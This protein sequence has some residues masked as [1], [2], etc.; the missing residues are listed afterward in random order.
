[1]AI[2]TPEIALSD[3]AELIE[4]TTIKIQMRGPLAFKNA[5]SL[6]GKIRGLWGRYLLAEAMRGSGEADRLLAAIYN[7]GG[8]RSAPF[9]LSIDDGREI[10]QVKVDLFGDVGRLRDVAASTLL[11]AISQGSPGPIRQS[12]L[13]ASDVLNCEWSRT[14]GCRDT[15]LGTDV[16]LKFLMPFKIGGRKTLSMNYANLWLAAAKRA[17]DLARAHGFNLKLS[18]ESVWQAASHLRHYDDAL[19]PLSWERWTSRNGGRSEAMMGFEGEL[20][21]GNW[22]SELTPLAR[23]AELYFIGA[24]TTFG[25]G[26]FEL[27]DR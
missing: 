18:R 23:L 9:C 12:Q 25:L 13:P 3:F 5:V 2:M 1:M 24:G 17:A 6:P 11:A 4:T 15:P 20:L 8:N 22:Q 26:R 10:T 7:P 19:Y 27:F 21:I 14:T 16:M